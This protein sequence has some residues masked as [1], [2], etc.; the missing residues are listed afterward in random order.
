[1]VHSS[2][3]RHSDL[4]SNY[5]ILHLPGTVLSTEGKRANTVNKDLCPSRVYALG[6]KGGVENEKRNEVKYM[7]Y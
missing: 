7:V 3:S 4:S 5:F 2:D 6:D 1:M